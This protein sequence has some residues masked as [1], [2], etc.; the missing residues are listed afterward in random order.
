MGSPENNAA[1]SHCCWP[2]PVKALFSAF[3]ALVHPLLDAGGAVAFDTL[4]SAF[5]L[6]VMTLVLAVL[7]LSVLSLCCFYCVLRSPLLHSLVVLLGSP[8][9]LAH[10]LIVSVLFAPVSIPPPIERRGLE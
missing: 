3:A 1:L 8:G 5:P 6:V 10:V 7:L 9:P 4:F 2:L